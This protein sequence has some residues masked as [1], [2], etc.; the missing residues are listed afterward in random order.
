MATPN[1]KSMVYHEMGLFQWKDRDL[2]KKNKKKSKV[3]SDQEK[4]RGRSSEMYVGIPVSEKLQSQQ[5]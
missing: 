5:C 2:L 3:P 1:I 4:V